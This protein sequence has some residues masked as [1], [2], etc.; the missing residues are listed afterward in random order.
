MIDNLIGNT[1]MVCINYKYKN[2]KKELYVK[3]E[4]YNYTGSIKDRMVWYLINKAKK[5][6]KLKEKQPIIEATSG[7]TGISLAAIGALLN[8]EVHIFMP[9]WASK[10]RISLMRL[11]GANVHLVSK[12]EGGF[13]EAIRRAD[14]LANEINGFRPNQFT[15]QDNIEAHYQTTAQEILNKKK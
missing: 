11:Y 4:Y 12:Q 1:P 7:N 5:E 13:R 6:N 9:D 2:I 10:E 14:I 15:N 3:L 8:H